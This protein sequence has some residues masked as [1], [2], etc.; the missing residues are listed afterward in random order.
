VR[1]P[2]L[3]LLL[4]A[5]GAVPDVRALP[6]VQVTEPVVDAGWDGGDDLDAGLAPEVDA[7]PGPCAGF[8]CR[9][10]GGFGADCPSDCVDGGVCDLSDGGPY[11]DEPA[12]FCPGASRADDQW[13]EDLADGGAYVACVVGCSAA[14]FAA[15]ETCCN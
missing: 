8:D 15:W 4:S 10:P 14:A 2:I 9:P 11:G 5:C 12:P 7:G 1:Y 3:I 6:Q 13:A